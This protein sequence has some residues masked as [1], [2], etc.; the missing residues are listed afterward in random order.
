M[1]GAA[2]RGTPL[3]AGAEGATLVRAHVVFASGAPPALVNGAPKALREAA[4]GLYA[5]PGEPRPGTGG[6][7]RAPCPRRALGASGTRL[8]SPCAAGRSR[9][10]A[11]PTA[12]LP[13][14]WGPL[15]SMGSGLN[16]EAGALDYSAAAAAGGLA[17]PDQGAAP[18]LALRAALAAM[19]PAA[20]AGAGC[21]PERPR[22]PRGAAA[23]IAAGGVL[24]VGA[25]G[26]IVARALVRAAGREGDKSAQ[27]A[28]LGGLAEGNDAPG[29]AAGGDSGAVAQIVM[30]PVRQ[31][32]L[33]MW[34]GSLSQA[35]DGGEVRRQARRAAPCFAGARALLLPSKWR[36]R[37]PHANTRCNPPRQADGASGGG[38]S[39]GGAAGGGGAAAPAVAPGAPGGG[40]ARPPLAAQPGAAFL[41]DEAEGD[42]AWGGDVTFQPRRRSRLSNSGG[43]PFARAGGGAKHRR[44]SG[45]A[46]GFAPAA[47]HSVGVD[48]AQRR[49][50]GG[51]GGGLRATL[52]PLGSALSGAISSGGGFYGD[53]D[54]EH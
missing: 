53:C 47:A 14:R 11:L 30:P 52:S 10:P 24:V 7:C 18:L 43:V 6:R 35:G 32:R 9:P 27:I 26:I 16:L 17:P 46:G 41:P 15:E 45:S 28:Y 25:A 44:M 2:A 38:W 12:A 36:H 31:G 4:A 23:A 20:C 39:K 33:L 3:A 34:L 5:R 50:T 48:T 8:A 49:T 1:D 13:A 54:K 51:G 19:P 22:L 42:G 21:A 37:T 29:D 40:R